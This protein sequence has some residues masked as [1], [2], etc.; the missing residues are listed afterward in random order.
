VIGNEVSIGNYSVVLMKD[1]AYDVTIAYYGGPSAGNVSSETD[2]VGSFTV[3][4]PAGEIAI[5]ENFGLPN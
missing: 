2:F 1:H 5:I 3:Q 4:A